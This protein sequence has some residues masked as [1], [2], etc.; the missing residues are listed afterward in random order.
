MEQI[1]WIYLVIFSVQSSQTVFL[2]ISWRRNKT[3]KRLICF[4]P[5]DPEWQSVRHT[6]NWLP[7]HTH[8]H[9]QVQFSKICPEQLKILPYTLP[10]VLILIT[11]P[12]I[13]IPIHSLCTGMALQFAS[14]RCRKNKLMEI[15]AKCVIWQ[16]EM[17]WY[18]PWGLVSVLFYHLFRDVYFRTWPASFRIG[19]RF[20]WLYSE[21]AV[22]CYF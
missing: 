4:C 14:Q 13:I 22:L 8:I 11:C 2:S 21:D 9:T 18:C 17:E 20:L 12:F 19:P 3:G 1:F 7:E 16:A 6:V 15:L 10:A 5:S